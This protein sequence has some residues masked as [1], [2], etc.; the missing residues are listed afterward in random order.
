M[1]E[2]EAALA[3]LMEQLWRMA[4]EVPPRPCSL[5]RVGKRAQ[6][7]MS[8]LMRALSLLSGSGLVEV[9]TREEGGGHVVLTAAGR[10]LCTNWFGAQPPTSDM[11][12]TG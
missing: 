2:G 7:P 11:R 9:A 4:R 8:T 1:N 6:L 3:G 12:T 5:A 10:D